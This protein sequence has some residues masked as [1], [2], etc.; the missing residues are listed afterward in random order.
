MDKQLLKRLNKT[1]T[2]FPYI[3][4]SGYGDAEY[5]P[6]VD[7]KCLM[8]GKISMVRNNAGEE[9]VS[10]LRVYFD[11]VFALTVDDKIVIEGKQYTI[12]DYSQYDGIIPGTGTTVVYL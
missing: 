5:G 2:H 1:A 8:Q 12:I 6:S 10:S 7:R 3:K 11:G 9:V 4:Q